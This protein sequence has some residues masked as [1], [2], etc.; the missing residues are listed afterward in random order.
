MASK[1]R[2]LT[3]VSLIFPVK[4]IK[5]RLF[6]SNQDVLLINYH[7]T[8]DKLSFNYY[9][10]LSYYFT[11]SLHCL[12][13]IWWASVLNFDGGKKHNTMSNWK[14]KHVAI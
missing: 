8:I 10:I 14:F 5:R 12:R 11:I 7:L 6:I 2:F 13:C 4:L 9:C 1:R 3:F